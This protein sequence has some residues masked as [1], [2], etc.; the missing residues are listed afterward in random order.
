MVSCCVFL[1]PVVVR[2]CGQLLCVPV[3]SHL[4]RGCGQL[5]CVPVGPHLARG[6]G[7][8]LGVVPILPGGVVSCCVSL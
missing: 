3:G 1:D 6:C 8:L 2:R 7:Q 4:A 5:L